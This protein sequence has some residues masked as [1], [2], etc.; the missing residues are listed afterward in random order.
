MRPDLLLLAAEATVS[1]GAP[2]SKLPFLPS[3]SGLQDLDGLTKDL[4]LGAQPEQPPTASKIS[5]LTGLLNLPSS[6]N[7]NNPVAQNGHITLLI[8]LGPEGTVRLR[9]GSRSPRGSIVASA[10]FLG[11]LVTGLGPHVDGHVTAIGADTSSRV[12]HEFSGLVSGMGRPTVGTVV[13]TLDQ[14][15]KRGAI[16]PDFEILTVTGTDTKSL[17]IELPPEVG[18][19]L[20]GLD[21]PSVG[22]PAAIIVKTADNIG[23]LISDISDP[24]KVLL[25]IIGNDGQKLLIQLSPEVGAL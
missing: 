2:V 17:L 20:T 13:A 8:E 22:T 10:R 5:D 3:L 16:L 4:Q 6:S 1:I 14:N 19:L 15:L 24:T 23:D 18:S 11:D 12:L 21:L 25:T 7:S 9:P